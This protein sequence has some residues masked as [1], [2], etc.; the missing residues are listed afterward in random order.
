MLGIAGIITALALLI[1]SRLPRRQ[2]AAAR[3]AAALLAA[4]ASDAPL[5]ASYTQVFMPAPAAS[6]SC[7]SR[8]SCSARSSA[9]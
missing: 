8:C 1:Y 4:L 2:R 3:A 5:L 6:S 7:T 9:S